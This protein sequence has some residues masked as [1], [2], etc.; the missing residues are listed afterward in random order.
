M[1]KNIVR[2][3]ELVVTLA[4]YTAGIILVLLML[5]TTLDVAGRY[6]LNSPITGVFDLTHFAVLT[7][8]FLGLAYCGF[9]DGHVSI[10][11]IYDKLPPRIRHFI[12]SAT[13]LAGCLLFLIVAWQAIVQSV[14]VRQLNETSQ[15]VE[16]PFFPFYWLLAF[17]SVLFAFVMGL[18]IFVKIPETEDQS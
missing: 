13:N 17:G 14:L 5:L 15:L 16:I 6:F 1:K 8:V 10:E 18:K 12:D 2:A 4:A 3:T 9:H 7:M 11:L